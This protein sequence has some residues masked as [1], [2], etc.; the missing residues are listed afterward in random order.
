MN[1]YILFVIYVVSSA[2]GMVL[3]KLGGYN[4]EFK[5]TINNIFVQ[6]NYQ[7]I[8]G[9]LL[10]MIS[11][12]IWIIILQKFQLTYISPIAYGVVFILVTVLS[13]YVLHETITIRNGVGFIL[14]I[15]GV[16]ISSIR[17]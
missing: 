11:F 1:K 4:A 5:M 17:K 14:I 2:L 3:I 6:I 16:L 15:L 12:P 10:Y 13:A 8:A 7:F 9:L